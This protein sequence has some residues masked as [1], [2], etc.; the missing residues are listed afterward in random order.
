ME[1][2]SFLIIILQKE[3]FQVLKKDLLDCKISKR[4]IEDLHLKGAE[5]EF[6]SFLI[7]SQ[8]EGNMKDNLVRTCPLYGFMALLNSGFN[9][10]SLF[11][12]LKVYCEF[13]ILRA[14]DERPKGAY[15]D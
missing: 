6:T 4:L 14:L 3:G 10:N 15:I 11:G 1:M 12:L 7:S 13:I 8:I 9:Y 5:K 2:L